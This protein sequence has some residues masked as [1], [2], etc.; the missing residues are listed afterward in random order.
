MA[1][2]ILDPR[3]IILA[4]DGRFVTLGRH[5]IPTEE[6]IAAAAAAIAAQGV[7]AWLATMSGTI[8]Q[9]RCPDLTM[10]RELVAPRQSWDAAV[11]AFRAAH[12]ARS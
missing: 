8:Y 9:R 12:K 1:R 3:T 2:P 10:R 4:D 5:S 6:E 7:G 11:A